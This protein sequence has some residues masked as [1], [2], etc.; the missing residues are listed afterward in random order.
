MEGL[1]IQQFL[2]PSAEGTGVDAQ[3]STLR[4]CQKHRPMLYN[5]R[6]SHFA[7]LAKSLDAF[8]RYCGLRQ[9][10]P[11]LSSA[12]QSQWPDRSFCATAS[13]FK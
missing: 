8:L 6:V 1:F 12:I 7:Y 2:K 13:R 9:L 10:A 3:V 5:K 11:S 4:P